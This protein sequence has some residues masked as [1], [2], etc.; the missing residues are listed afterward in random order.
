MDKEPSLEFLFASSLGLG[1]A[2]F[3]LGRKNPLLAIPFALLLTA[4]FLLFHSEVS[5]PQVGPAIV[6][7]AG[8]GYVRSGYAVLILGSVLTLAGV[9]EWLVRRFRGTSVEPH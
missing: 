1:G 2:A 5:D 3:F 6:A 9:A 8:T 7:E 4:F